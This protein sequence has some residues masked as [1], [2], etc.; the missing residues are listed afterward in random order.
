MNGPRWPRDLQARETDEFAT[1][2][3]GALVAL[4]AAVSLPHGYAA[5]AYPAKVIKII[6]PFPPGGP[7]DIAMRIVQAGLE[8][9]L[10]QPIIVENVPG[11]EA[12]SARRA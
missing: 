11:A 6:V 4:L 12:G 2:C 5:Q 10:G 8:P 9:A 3:S 7:G 1:L